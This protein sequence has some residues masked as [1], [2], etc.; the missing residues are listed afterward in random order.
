M[1]VGYMDLTLVVHCRSI[2][3]QYQGF[4][5]VQLSCYILVIPLLEH[6]HYYFVM[7]LVNHIFTK[8]LSMNTPLLPHYQQM[9]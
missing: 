5:Q 1:L 8:K 7:K 2:L 3:V 4:D 6:L 9:F